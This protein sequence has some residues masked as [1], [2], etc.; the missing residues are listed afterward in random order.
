MLC[1]LIHRKTA[2]TGTLS[3]FFFLCWCCTPLC[4]RPLGLVHVVFVRTARVFRALH[5][6]VKATSSEFFEVHLFHVFAEDI[7]CGRFPCDTAENHAI[8]QRVSAEAVVAMN[9]TSNLAGTV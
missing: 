1:D 2:S 8:Q 3:L 6:A 5:S 9:T 4:R 7:F